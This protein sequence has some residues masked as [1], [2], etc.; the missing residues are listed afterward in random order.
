MSEAAGSNFEGEK[1]PR[2][3]PFQIRLLC[4]RE[5]YNRIHLH[6]SHNSLYKS[7]CNITTPVRPRCSLSSTAN[8]FVIHVNDFIAECCKQT[9]RT[10]Y[11]L[12]QCYLHSSVLTNVAAKV[13]SL[14]LRLSLPYTLF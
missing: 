3:P 9:N 2:H 14:F 13:A 4:I 5:L 10:S 7:T 11:I 8:A 1:L 12:I 6:F